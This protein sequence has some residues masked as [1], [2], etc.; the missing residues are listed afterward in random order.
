[1]GLPVNLH[2]TDP[3]SGNYPGRVATPLADFLALARRFPAT[4]FVLAHWGGLLP[5]QSPEAN[6][7]G[8]IHYDTSA[9]SLIYDGEIWR[10]FLAA[11]PADRVLFGSDFPLRLYPRR[12][13]APGMAGLAAEARGAG[14]P[15][16]TREAVLDGNARR[17][18]F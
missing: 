6:D 17:L 2:V 16:A 18:F 13:A 12:E 7:L 5:L 1:M 10:R 3:E 15:P 14:L 4:T 8:N 9:S 11:V